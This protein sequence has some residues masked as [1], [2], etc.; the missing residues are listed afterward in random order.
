[1]SKRLAGT[2]IRKIAWALSIYGAEYWSSM[3]GAAASDPIS[4]GAVLP[5]TGDAAHWG[6]PP[7]NGAQ[8]SI[9]EVNRAGGMAVG[10]SRSS[11]PMIG[12]ARPKACPRSTRSWQLQAQ[13]QSHRQ[14]WARYAAA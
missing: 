12:A 1:M 8:L 9:E 2:S 5:L 4:I 14:S 7:R 13:P 11:S 10:S 3:S 6:I